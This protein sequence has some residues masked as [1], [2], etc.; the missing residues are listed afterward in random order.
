VTW[1]EQ[2]V[3]AG[4]D[5]ECQITF[6]NIASLTDGS[7]A[8]LDGNNVN[9]ERHRKLPPG[10]GSLGH[11]GPNVYRT[12]SFG[13]GHRPSSSFSFPA[14]D[15]GFEQGHEPWRNQDVPL[16]GDPRRNH[17]R[18]VSILSIGHAED[19]PSDNKSPNG[20][21]IESRRPRGHGRAASLQMIP[22][23]LGPNGAGPPSGSI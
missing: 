6:R 13:K 8:G 20:S 23:R 22:R 21:T 7:H 4:E 16:G 11:K 19:I 3:F 14:G 18:S 5:I 10:K 2:T 1:S 17:K 12:S 9:Q 15:G